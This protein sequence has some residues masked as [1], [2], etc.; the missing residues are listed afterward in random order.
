M[1]THS[2][3]R[4]AARAILEVGGSLSQLLR[5]GRRRSSAYQ[6]NLDLGREETR[7]VASKLVDASGENWEARYRERALQGFKVSRNS[8]TKRPLA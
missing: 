6:P 4:G 3:R 5:S 2:P 8:N 7:A 1:R